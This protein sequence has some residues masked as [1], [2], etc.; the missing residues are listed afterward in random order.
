MNHEPRSQASLE[1]LTEM[2]VDLTGAVQEGFTRVE[3][4]IE[5]LHEGQEN[6]KERVGVLEGTVGKLV[7]KVDEMSDALDG[8]ARA[9]DKD[10]VTLV[11]HE[12]RIARLE[13]A[14]A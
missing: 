9:V 5:V 14:A 8:L 2:V 7:V 13:K 12:G 4:S 1:N 10:A 11:N 6:L 3:K